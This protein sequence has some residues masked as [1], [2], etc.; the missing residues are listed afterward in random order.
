MTRVVLVAAA[1]TAMTIGVTVLL[2]VAL[3][4]IGVVVNDWLDRRGDR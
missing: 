4:A 1:S 2:V 3:V